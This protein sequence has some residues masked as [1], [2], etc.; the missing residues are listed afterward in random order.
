MCHIIGIEPYFKNILLNGPSVPI[1]AGQ[2]KPERQWT[3]DERKTVNLDQRLKSLIMSVLFDDQMNSVINCEIAKSTW[4]DLILYH[5]GPSDV[6]ETRARDLKLC[7]NTFKFKED[8][9]LASLFGKLKYEENLIENIYETEK[10][11]SL[12]TTTPLSSAFFS[13][14]IVQDFR[15]SPDDEEDTRSSEE[16]R[17]DLKEEYHERALLAKKGHF[18]RDC[19]SK[20]L[21]PSYSSPFQKPQTTIFSHSQQKPKLIPTKY[22]E[23]RY[24]KIKAKLAVLSSGTSTSK[25]SMVKNKVKVLMAL[26]NDE[27]VAVGK[28]TARNGDW[29]KISMRKVHT[30]LDMEE[31]DDGKSFLDYL[32]IDLNYVEEQRND[33]VLKHRNLVHELNT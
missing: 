30:L 3:A 13:N 33:L 18:A 5:E 28:E 4:D 1:T 19:F 11:K 20:T 26:A 23:A 10:I 15:D 21:V 29:V 17:K 31:N 16:Y 6:K 14:S 24:N 25:S 32:C 7:Y 2:K 8:S 12:T 22:F 27:N 9:E